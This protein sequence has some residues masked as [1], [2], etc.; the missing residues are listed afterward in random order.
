MTAIMVLHNF[1]AKVGALRT[2]LARRSAGLDHT[3]GL[4]KLV[5]ADACTDTA[6]C[7]QG[8]EGGEGSSKRKCKAWRI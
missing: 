3:R 1:A 7:E 8:G 5:L 2:R 6:V 4:H